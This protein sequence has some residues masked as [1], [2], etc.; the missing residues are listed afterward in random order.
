MADDTVRAYIEDLQR[1]LKDA[2]TRKEAYQLMA[3]IIAVR[4]SEG[5]QR[6]G[7][8]LSAK[9]SAY[10]PDSRDIAAQLQSLYQGEEA[11]DQLYELAQ[12][13][14]GGEMLEACRKRVARLDRM[15]EELPHA[16][17]PTA[18]DR[19]ETLQEKLR[20]A[21]EPADKWR[22]L[23]EIINVRHSAKVERGGKGLENA[24]YSSPEFI[25]RA[26]EQLRL[27]YSN[28]PKEVDQLCALAQRGHG[29][30]MLESCR[31]Q[32]A[33]RERMPYDLELQ[34]LF[35]SAKDRIEAIQE[36]LRTDTN[37]DRERTASRIAEI[38]AART[39]AEAQ[40]GG[41]GLEHTVSYQTIRKAGYLQKDILA[42][43]DETFRA[44]VTTA[45]QGH[46]GKMTEL[47]RGAQSHIRQAKQEQPRQGAADDVGHPGRYA[48][49]KDYIEAIQQKLKKEPNADREKAAFR[50][51]EI[52]AAREQVGA[53]RG[54]KGLENPADEEAVQRARSLQKDLLLLPDETLRTLTTT[55][56]RGHGGEMMELFKGTETQ[57][58]IQH[59]KQKQDTM[60][61]LQ[62]Q[63][64]RGDP[65]QQ[66]MLLAKMLYVKSIDPAE[67]NPSRWALQFSEQ[68][69]SEAA[70]QI[71]DSDAFRH[72]KANLKPE[73]LEAA[74][75]GNISELADAFDSA[76]Q[77]AQQERQEQQ[78]Q[79]QN[80]RPERAPEQPNLVP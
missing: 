44:L 38:I 62:G 29:G 53:Q 70:Q 43:P 46:G 78:P 27:L 66:D 79:R 6:G 31:R 42:L 30:E 7:K 11:L 73:A 71:A 59:A 40:R 24:C 15:P 35:P 5:I 21:Q 16:L 12:R 10:T 49:A 9:K 72:F 22:C 8:G 58:Y 69:Q 54:G 26:A 51:A 2:E 64:Q 18:K 20:T 63:L 56:T 33:S 68:Q 80:D 14:H 34:G 50:I 76:A 25:D 60:Q 57:K 77:K 67:T 61:A 17:F 65:E 36:K 3:E 45:T 39:E 48:S 75:N 41:K 28:D 13:G 4:D 32:V 52:I 74:K 37:A 23:A 1:R 55:A 47:F 19:I